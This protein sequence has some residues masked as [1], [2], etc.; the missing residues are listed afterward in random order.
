MLF[1][2]SAMKKTNDDLPIGILALPVIC[3]KTQP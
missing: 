3:Q 1:F 2:S